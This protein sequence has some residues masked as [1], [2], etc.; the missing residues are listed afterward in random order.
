MVGRIIT[1]RVR[2]PASTP[3]FNPIIWMKN[4][5]PTRPKMMEGMPVR[6]SVANSMTATRRRLV[7]YS[8]R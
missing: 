3:V 7:A 6:V 1:T 4:S 5:I 2:P 8:V